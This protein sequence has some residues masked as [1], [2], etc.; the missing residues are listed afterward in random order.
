M[1]QIRSHST[2]MK[3]F[4]FSLMFALVFEVTLNIVAGKL[5]F[6]KN[7]IVNFFKMRRILRKCIIEYDLFDFHRRIACL[8][9]KL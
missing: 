6:K 3:I 7:P 5:Y 8:L 9:I 1:R 4:V 2:K